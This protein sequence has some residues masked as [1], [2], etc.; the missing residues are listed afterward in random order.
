MNEPSQSHIRNINRGHQYE[1]EAITFFELTSK[2]KVQKCGFF[3][4]PSDARYGSSP[5]ALG[6]SGILLE[7]K[8]RAENS[9]GPLET[10]PPQY[11][12]QCQLQMLCTNAEFCIL[13]SYHPETKTSKFFLI[14]RNNVLMDIVIG[15][16]NCIYNEEHL[17]D[18]VHEDVTELKN[19]SKACIGKI[20]NFDLL[21][22]LRAYMKKCANVVPSIKFIDEV[23]FSII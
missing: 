20:P 6:P 19:F 4:L 10:I 5:D 17:L 3:H 18:W 2:C 7:V 22:G 8:T 1:D 13:Q 14:E 9:E 23:D 11:F 15:V 16:V 21:K 12:T